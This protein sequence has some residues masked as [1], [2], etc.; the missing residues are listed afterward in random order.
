MPVFRAAFL[1]PAR[2]K[3]CLLPV[4]SIP[5]L[6]AEHGLNYEGGIKSSWLQQRLYV[7]VNAFYYQLRNAIVQRRDASGA[8]YFANAG[9][10]PATRVLNRRLSYQL[11]PKSNRFIQDARIWVSHTYEQVPVSGF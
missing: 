10:T 11:L 1:H 3:Y 8:D 5:S 2:Q 4:S 7:E 9:N 6:Q